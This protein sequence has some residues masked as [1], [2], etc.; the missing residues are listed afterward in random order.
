MN[1]MKSTQQGAILLVSLIMLLAITLIAISSLTS[2]TLETKMVAS[3]QGQERAF[4]EAE[5]AIEQVMDQ[6]AF[7]NITL[8]TAAGAYVETVDGNYDDISVDTGTEYER[9]SLILGVSQDVANYYHFKTTARA[10]QD[11]GPGDTTLVQGVKRWGFA[12]QES[13]Q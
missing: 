13:A 3:K 9:V 10:Q 5:S 12:M 7:H 6:N 1:T 11:A 2:S 8:N 4:Q